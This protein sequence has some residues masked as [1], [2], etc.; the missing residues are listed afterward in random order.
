M[1]EGLTA[2]FLPEPT[3]RPASARKTQLPPRVI[4]PVF[5]RVVENENEAVRLANATPFGLAPGVTADIERRKVAAK[6]ESGMVFINQPVWTAAQLPFGGIKN[7]ASAV[8]CRSWALGEFVN[9]KLINVAPPVHRHG[10]CQ[11]C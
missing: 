1:A 11:I 8:S 2:W 10:T 9:E 7:S 3:V 6:I 4:C 5:F